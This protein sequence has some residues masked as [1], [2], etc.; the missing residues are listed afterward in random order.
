MTDEKISRRRLLQGA[1]AGIAA[2]PAAALMAQDAA[3]ANVVAESDANAKSLGYVA[4]ARAVNP[5]LNPSYKAGQT[6]ANCF[7]YKGKAGAPS[8]P[9]VIFDNK[10]VMAA[11]WCRVWVPKT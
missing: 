10:F 5:N 4:D 8:G 7:Q 11:G 3:A 9:C 6:C 2:V 1:I